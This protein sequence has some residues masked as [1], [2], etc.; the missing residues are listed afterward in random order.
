MA[1]K[2]TIIAAATAIAILAGCDK[3][4]N[5]TNIDK[6]WT[7]HGNCCKT[8][9]V[10]IDNHKYIIMDGNYSGNIIHAASCQCMNK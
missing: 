4:E 7:Y 5:D 6:V 9:V 8:K 2:M 3:V 1:N 10:N